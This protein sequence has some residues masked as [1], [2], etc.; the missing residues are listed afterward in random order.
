LP[1]PTIAGFLASCLQ[2]LRVELGAHDVPSSRRPG[3]E[4]LARR[5]EQGI[6]D[7]GPPPLEPC[8]ICCDEAEIPE[9]VRDLVLTL[10]RDHPAPQLRNAGDVLDLGLG[11]CWNCRGTKQV[12][13][14]QVPR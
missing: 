12:R 2:D 1:K 5:L 3:L 14:P 6:R 4:A 10:R 9:R 11:V 13:G 7:Y 8:L